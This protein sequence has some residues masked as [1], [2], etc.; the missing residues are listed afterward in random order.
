MGNKKKQRTIEYKAR[1]AVMVLE[2]WNRE[3]AG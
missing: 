3:N 1:Q 2:E